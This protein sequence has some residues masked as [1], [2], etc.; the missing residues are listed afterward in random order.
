MHLVGYLY[1]D[2]HDARSLEH[3]VCRQLFS[4]GKAPITISSSYSRETNR[5]PQDIRLIRLLLT[6]IF[7]TSPFWTITQRVVVIPYRSFGT[8]Y[9]YNL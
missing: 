1:E 4:Y 9:R 7:R 5:N 3:E 2:C 6:K 8:I